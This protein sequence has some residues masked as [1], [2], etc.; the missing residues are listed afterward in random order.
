[1]SRLLA[2]LADGSV[3]P[4]SECDWIMWAPCGCPSGVA[5]ASVGGRTL[6]TEESVWLDWYDHRADRRKAQGQ[7][8]RLELV[9]HADYAERLLPLFLSACPHAPQWGIGGRPAPPGQATLY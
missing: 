2:E 6:A 4:L 7:G 5:M 1:M 3:L 9:A 8:F